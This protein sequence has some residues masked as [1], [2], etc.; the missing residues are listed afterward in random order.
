MEQN[1]LPTTIPL[2]D[3]DVVES[4]KSLSID[5]DDDD[6]DDDDDDD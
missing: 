4:P 1:I 5:F 6:W 2:E 3:A